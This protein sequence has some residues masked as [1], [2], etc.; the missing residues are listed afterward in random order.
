V[1]SNGRGTYQ[2]A[3]RARLPASRRR[4]LFVIRSKLLLKHYT[5]KNH[6]YVGVPLNDICCIN[7]L[8][9]R[10]LTEIKNNNLRFLINITLHRG[11]AW[12]IINLNIFRLE[13][14]KIFIN[15]AFEY[16]IVEC[17]LRFRKD[18]AG[19]RVHYPYGHIYNI[20]AGGC[21]VYEAK[22][23]RET[24]CMIS[25]MRYMRTVKMKTENKIS[26]FS[27]HIHFFPI[28][29]LLILYR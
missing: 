19:S 18:T 15:I 21:S 8:Y 2:T 6:Y 11:N 24:L 25:Y 16:I 22:G 26:I 4:R 9:H 17:I 23:V 5:R 29:L 7:I 12:L 3:S 28:M 14:L 20:L 13:L 27:K 10:K 1:D